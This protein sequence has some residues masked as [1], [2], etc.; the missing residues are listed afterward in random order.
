MASADLQQF[1]EDRL[2][3]LDPTTDISPGSAA[4]TKFIHPVLSYLGT[5]PFETD[6]DTFVTDRFA[7][8]FPDIYANDPGALRD[9][10]INPLR[11]ILEPFKRE[12]QTIKKN[13]SLVDPSVLSD[14]DADALIANFFDSRDQGGYA[15]GAV[16]LY[17]ANPTDVRIDVA[18]R[19]YSGS[20]LNFFPTNPVVSSAESMAF[21][22]D[23]SFFYMDVPL[24]AENAGS[25]YNIGIDEISGIEGVP[26]VIKVSNLR[27]FT[28]GT[29]RQDTISFASAA[30]ESLTERSL[31]TRR[32]ARARLNTV[33]KGALR[34]VQVVGAKDA[35]MQRD[36]LVAASP[37]HAWITGVVELYKQVA[38]VRART[39]EGEESAIP[40]TGDTLY[41]YLPK[42]SVGGGGSSVSRMFGAGETGQFDGVPQARRFVR[43][44]VAELLF[45]PR[46]ST[47]EFQTGYF[48][49][50]E[51]PDAVLSLTFGVTNVQ[52]FLDTLPLSFEGGFTKKGTI[53]VTSIPDIGDV[54]LT[55]DNQS[56][57]I[58]GRSDIY[59]R[60][61][62]Q[63]TTKAV[64]DGVYD[65]GKLGSTTQNPHFFLERLGLLTVSGS[66]IVHDLSPDF[67]FEAAGVDLGDVLSIE[68]GSD[69]GLYVIGDMDD[70]GNLYLNQ[71][72]T[73]ASPVNGLRYRVLKQIRINPFEARI[74]RFPFGDAEQ[75]DLRTTIGSNLITT[76]QNDL[77][78]FGARVGDTVRVLEGLDVG[79]YTIQSFDSKLGGQGIYLDR[80]LTATS[81]N[82]P[83][84]V[85]TPLESVIRPLVRVRELLLLDS[86]K[87][88][89][90]LTIPPA[91]PAA[92]I[93]TGPLTSAKVLGSSQLASGYVLP[94]LSTL[95]D[96]F[97]ST[98]ADSGDRRY[99]MGFDSPDG[100]YLPVIFP[101]G[102]QAELDFRSDSQGKTSFFMATTESF[103]DAVNTPPIDPNPGECFTIKN[104]PNK[105]SYLIKAVHKF[106]YSVGGN[107]PH[108]SLL[109]DSAPKTC[110]VYFLQIYGTFPVD[111][112]KRLIEF[113][114]EHGESIG[115]TSG[116]VSLPI[117]F[118]TFFQNWYASLG[119]KVYNALVDGGISDPP[120]GEEL[121]GVVDAMSACYYDWGLPAR[122][123]LRTYFR[124][125]TLFEEKTGDADLVTT[126]SYKT[127][128]GDFAKFR[129]DPL[130][131]TQYEVV[132]PRLTSDADPTSYP[133]DLDPS[134]QANP[135]FADSS[136]LS[137]FSAGVRPGDVLSVREEVFLYTTRLQQAVV[138]TSAGSQQLTAPDS[139]D[140][141]FT[142]SMVGNLL[143]IEEG[144]DQGGYHI[145]RYIDGRN[146]LVDRVLQGSTSLISK[147]GAGGDYFYDA[148]GIY[149]TGANV[150]V[151]SSGD[152]PWDDSDVGSY[153]TLF[154]MDYRWMGSFPILQVYNKDISGFGTAIKVQTP[155]QT[156]FNNPSTEEGTV[157]WITT[158]APSTAPSNISR[159]VPPPTTAPTGTELVGAVPIRIYE[160]VATDFTFQSI[161]H[162]ASVSGGAIAP[163]DTLRQGVRQPYR[164]YRPNVRR[165]T[166]T[167]MSQNR[168]GFLYY[169]DT[170]IVSLA[171]SEQSNLAQDSYLT[172]DE[173]TYNS[174]GYRHA[175]KDPNFTYSML[176]DGFLDLPINILPVGSPDS[177]DSLVRVVG[178]PVQI[179]YERSS[180][181]E[182]VQDFIDSLDDRVLSAG[183]LSR[184]FLPAYV[185]YDASYTGGDSPGAI[186][187]DLQSYIDQLPVETAV[188]V[189]EME[190]IIDN[191]SGNPDTP[192]KISS[193][194]YDWNRRMWVEFSENQLGGAAATDTKVPYNGSPRVT[195]FSP[196]QDVSGLTDIPTGERINLTRR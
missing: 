92:V 37:G 45:G 74:V 115:L 30:E 138:Q 106:K 178:S 148:G 62:T 20:N 183:L 114:M 61:T 83:F 99:S 64:V 52:S 3:A 38:Y 123:V 172:T 157:R 184:H 193:T 164:I 16:R 46:A 116:D 27:A 159:D 19:V 10:F 86:A 39:I 49:R 87:Q 95:L 150:V 25:S 82:I 192:T 81:F 2:V 191:H 113:L 179:T 96:S 190:K 48:V 68:E 195:F 125:P 154:G 33:F 23:G 128:T 194:V 88:S 57:H 145:T 12:V 97:S 103:D 102:S 130:R 15:V 7:Q 89:T 105:G 76:A 42:V 59:V 4:Q 139:A 34:S 134:D 79:D 21:N 147:Q 72:L 108:P 70:S 40:Q 36:I 122:G 156:Q 129:P 149:A 91:D 73:A 22:R 146:V 175:V 189:S 161:L 100:I 126:R 29:D 51:D 163:T 117:P 165:I 65:L 53:H 187:T 137:I 160:A 14:E 181:V 11:I 151:A 66:N 77:L 136:R 67:A 90:G 133:R 18:N 174:I 84:E 58:F 107:V 167:E 152:R 93:P 101:D 182:L 111:P 104:G 127:S 5:D 110:Y 69:A 169:F 32:G 186:A 6:I 132:P 8:E 43:L 188:D 56:V 119:E 180:L 26:N 28:G 1:L 112:T 162:D 140:T 158:T 121:Q 144:S 55:V 60:P 13:Q 168:E 71:K 141:V 75:R 177:T 173:G 124:E 94:D 31:V 9:I 143:F 166:S 85:F 118:P 176:E 142:A 50:W 131:Y 80:K 153:I 63:D 196:G 98:A 109:G 185:S 54:S 171:P 35:E 135:V 170:E 78:Q 155:S 47:G 24:R 120:S 17:F 41:F 44:K